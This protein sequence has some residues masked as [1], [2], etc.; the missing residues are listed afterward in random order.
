MRPTN[1]E[2]SATEERVY[3]THRSQEEGLAISHGA[4]W[5]ST[6]VRQ[7]AREAGGSIG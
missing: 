2:M 6:R 4:T 5:G 1:W 3:Y 7:E